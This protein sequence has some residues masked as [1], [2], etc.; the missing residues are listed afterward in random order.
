MKIIPAIDIKEGKCVRLLKGNFNRETEYHKNP[1]VIAQKF[2]GMGFRNLHLVDLD[3]AKSGGQ[4]NQSIVEKIAAELGFV[5]HLGGVT[6]ITRATRDDCF[7]FRRLQC[8]D[9]Q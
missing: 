9:L 1:V 5:M 7:Q 8:C 6:S 4:T 2:E 3:G